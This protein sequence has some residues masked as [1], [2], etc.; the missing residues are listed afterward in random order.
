MIDIA[1]CH[2]ADESV[3]LNET[4]LIR[5]RREP[6]AKTMMV[7]HREDGPIGPA[8]LV[9]V[10]LHGTRPALADRQTGQLYDANT[11]RCMSGPLQLVEM[12]A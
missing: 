9:R 2:I 11:L 7:C 12:A 10:K 5:V 1:Q 3:C 8:E 4:G 6:V